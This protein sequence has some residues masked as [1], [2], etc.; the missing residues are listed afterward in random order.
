VEPCNDF[1]TLSHF[2]HGIFNEGR[3]GWSKNNILTEVYGDYGKFCKS[4]KELG[5]LFEAEKSGGQYIWKYTLLP[6]MPVKIIY[7]EG[8]D[9]FPSRLQILY[10]KTAI[11]FY[12]FEPLAALHICLIEGLAAVGKKLQI[13]NAQRIEGV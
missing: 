9:E 6:K 13:E 10:D 2:S 5:M 4:A 7:Y 8:D 12:K 11:Q 1:C 3:E